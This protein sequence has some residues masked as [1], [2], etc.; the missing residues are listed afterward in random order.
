MAPRDDQ[1]VRIRRKESEDWGELFCEH[2]RLRERAALLIVY[3]CNCNI[4]I[5]DAEEEFLPQIRPSATMWDSIQ[6]TSALGQC[7]YFH[8]VIKYELSRPTAGIQVKIHG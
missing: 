4:A 2:L 3:Q 1:E 7:S 6:R 5:S 8:F